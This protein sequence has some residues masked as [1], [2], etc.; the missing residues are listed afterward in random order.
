MLV[1]SEIETDPA[2]LDPEVGLAV[3]ALP[4]REAPEPVGEA[5]APRVVEASE[6]KSVKIWLLWYV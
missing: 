2:P 1:R 6:R 3:D 5:E 4:A